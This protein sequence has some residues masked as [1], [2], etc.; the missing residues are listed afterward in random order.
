MAVGQGTWK[1]RPVA[2]AASG[3]AQPQEPV[4]EGAAAVPSPPSRL[5]HRDSPTPHFIRHPHWDVQPS[6]STGGCTAWADISVKHHCFFFCHVVVL[7]N[8]FLTMAYN[9]IG[10]MY[11]V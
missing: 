3:P 11:R 6:P 2:P 10:H 4:V 9:K 7:L 1:P 8:F 5:W